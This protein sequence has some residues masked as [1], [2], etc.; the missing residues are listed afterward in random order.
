MHHLWFLK[1]CADTSCTKV[2]S[3][4]RCSPSGCYSVDCQPNRMELMT[5][6]TIVAALK[7][8]PNR[9]QF[10]QYESVTLSCVETGN[11]SEWR[12]KRNTSKYINEECSKGWGRRNDSQCLLDDFYQSDAGVY[13][14]ESGDGARSRAI[15][16]TVTGGS[17]I[18]ESPVLPVQEGDA[19]TL[20]CINRA[21]S[22]ANLTAQFY[23]DNLFIASS[24]TGN[25]TIYNV[26]KSDEG[27]YK[28]NISGAGESPD[29]WLAVR[30]GRPEPFHLHL[31]YILLPV[32]GVCLLLT[33]V[34]LLWLWR[35]HKGDPD[36][37]YTDVI[38][39]PEVRPK[40]D[41]EP[42]PEPTIYS[43]IRPGAT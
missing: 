23:K 19:V 10:F 7:V 24:S 38:I 37:S 42:D 2:D 8:V 29:S 20:R 40:R 25:M 32:V 15:N 34:M 39:T 9:S 3:N 35:R 5:L 22:S 17:V 14:C 36:V 12:V 28:C 21:T 43:T 11:S 1:C 18:L 13:W 31:A 30:A 33:S 16:I 26:S 27:L 4:V 6:C 41:K